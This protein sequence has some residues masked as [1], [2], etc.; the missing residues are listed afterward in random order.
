MRGQARKLI[1]CLS[2]TI[3]KDTEWEDKMLWNKIMFWAQDNILS[4]ENNFLKSPQNHKYS[5]F[6]HNKIV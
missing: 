5:D 1:T 2:K 4:T 6:T 3:L